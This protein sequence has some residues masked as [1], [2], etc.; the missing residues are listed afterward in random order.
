MG[1]QGL[2]TEDLRCFGDDMDDRRKSEHKLY[3]NTRMQR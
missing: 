1:L 3:L 2:L